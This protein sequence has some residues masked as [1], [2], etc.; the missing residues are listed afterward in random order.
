[1]FYFTADQV[2]DQIQ[3]TKKNFVNTVVFDKSARDATID[4]IDAQTKIAKLN[5]KFVQDSVETLTK[6]GK[7]LY[8]DATK[9]DY[10]K[11]FKQP[12]AKS[13]E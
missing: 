7:K 4:F 6:E 10:T 12:T 13:A 8:E 2:I 5:A 1:M 9:F 3:N 11:F